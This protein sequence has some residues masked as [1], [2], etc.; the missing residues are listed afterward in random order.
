MQYQFRISEHHLDLVYNHLFPGDGLE[1]VSLLL[2]GYHLAD[3]IMIFTVHDYF[4]VP[5]SECERNPDLINWKTESIIEALEKA[6]KFNLSVFKIH[7]H[8]GGYN[9]FSHLDDTAD[10]AL[11]PS[12]YGWVDGES[13]HGS[14]V[15][16]PDKTIFGRTI[17]YS[18]DFAEI[19]K[20][21]VVGNGYKIMNDPNTNV[22]ESLSLRNI[23]T[24]GLGTVNLLKNLKIT[25][26]GASG[27]GSPVI[28][29]LVRLGVGELVIVD[30]DVVEEKN[31][32][33]IL[34]TTKK[35]SNLKAFKVDVLKKR[36]EEI[37]FGTKVKVF[38]KNLYDSKNAIYEI[39]KSDFIFGCVDTVD[40]RHL[41]NQI[42]T[43]YLIPYIDIGV[44]LEADGKGNINQING[45][46]HYI[47]PG[48][49]SLLSRRVYTIESLDA[50]NLYR[51]NPEE[52]KER[53]KEKYI[54]N[55]EV[56]SPAVISVNM[57]M[58]SYAVNEFLDRIHHYKT[59]SLNGRAKIYISITEDLMF[60]EEDGEPDS[61]LLKKVGRGDIIPFLEMPEL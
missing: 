38:K 27:T 44:K 52:Y 10:L 48:G 34:N 59:S 19:T 58:A 6:S 60:L 35:D 31:L 9:K 15:M 17:S 21:S 33:R 26:V 14:L 37:G 5:Y 49:S 22:D 42:S 25:V 50:A 3:D 30:H 51:Q 55:I 56:P 39:I 32:N 18:G 11:M 20:F 43:F 28:E 29:Q 47:Q 53:L 12:I 8:P 13:A 61:Y 16:L 40:A 45:V 54:K 1:A 41:L 2:C 57:L 24:F 7:S 46:V 4:N 36:I 23:Q